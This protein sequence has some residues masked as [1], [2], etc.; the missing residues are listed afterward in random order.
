MVI[1]PALEPRRVDIRIYGPVR[2]LVDGH[3]LLKALPDAGRQVLA[4]LAICGELTEDEIVNSLGAGSRIRS[5]E[6]GS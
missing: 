2:V 1:P 4:L 6:A 5:G 3:E